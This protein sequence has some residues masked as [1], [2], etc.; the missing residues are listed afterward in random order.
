MIPSF[1]EVWFLDAEFYQPDGELPEPICLVSRELF[2][3]TVR[4]QWLWGRQPRNPPFEARTDVLVVA[5]SA[6]A[7]W[8]V[9]L[10]LGWPLP[11]RILDLYAEFRWLMSGFK[12]PS[13]GQL[14]AMDAFQ[15]PRME[16]QTKEDMRTLCRRGGP[17]TSTERR[18]ILA[19][20]QAD[21]DG[22]ATLFAAMEKHIQWP[23]ALARGRYTTAVAKIEAVGV[24]IDSDL[25]RRLRDNRERIYRDLIKEMDEQFGVYD[26]ARFD[27]RRFEDYL[28]AED[29]PW[30][31][32]PTGRLVTREETF[33]EM[34]VVYPQLRLLYELRS[35]LSQLKS[36]DG[37]SVGTDNRNR[38]SLRPFATV[39]GRNAPSTTRW[40]FSKSVAFRSL[41]L[42]DPG[43]AVGYVDWSAQEIGIASV[44]SGDANMRRAYTS[45]DCYLEFA[46]Q[47]GAIPTDATKETHREVR[48]V[49]KT[50]ML[51]VNYCM[52]EKAL[53]P[54]PKTA[55][56]RSRTDAVP[57]PGVPS[58]L[59]MG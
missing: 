30:P 29:I 27:S 20:C 47:A 18:E 35:A 56:L 1:H 5:Y 48:E 44:L 22:L 23:Q 58:L 41:V 51:A 52:A 9:Y 13:Y 49:F 43:W 10:A 55:A 34:A 12:L 38:T 59:A 21:V 36:D 8:G 28:A 53:A 54:H 24:P 11:C 19:Y 25:Y 42:P 33:E 40:I 6:A 45:G 15:L 4:R 50:V 7:E 17:F 32:T 26:E 39:T 3:G 14:A 46:K 37:L 2:S 16:A 31:R 57:S